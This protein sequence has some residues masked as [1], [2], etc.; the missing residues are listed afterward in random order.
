MHT[1]TTASA[2]YCSSCAC[3]KTLAQDGSMLLH[4]PNIKVR[5]AGNPVLCKT[6]GADVTDL[7]LLLLLLLLLHAL[8]KAS[9][10]LR[11]WRPK[12]TR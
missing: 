5:R 12:A 8:P 1:R 9:A 4:R 7:L 2:A 10:Q 11:T 6:A 3:C